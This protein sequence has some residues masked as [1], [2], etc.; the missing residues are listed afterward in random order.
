MLNV[1][2]ID[3]MMKS[4][5]KVYGADAIG[6]LMTGMGRDG[7]EGMR[8]IKQS[9]GRTIAQD[10][11]SSVIFGMNKLAIDLDFVDNVV[12]L[13]GIAQMLTNLAGG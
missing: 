8:A 7:V 12:S 1:P 9:G 5:A 13:G 2:S 10:E 4:V 3:S 11:Q 6:V